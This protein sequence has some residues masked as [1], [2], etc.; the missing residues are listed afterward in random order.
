MC[1]AH[2]CCFRILK[3]QSHMQHGNIFDGVGGGASFFQL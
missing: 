1:Y 3:K 2:W